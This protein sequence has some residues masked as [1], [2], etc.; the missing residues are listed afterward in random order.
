M[1]VIVRLLHKP[2]RCLKYSEGVR[3]KYQ[4]RNAMKVNNTYDADSRFSA[5]KNRA[6]IIYEAQYKMPH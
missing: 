2:I 1:F 3:E 6:L 4:I 5:T